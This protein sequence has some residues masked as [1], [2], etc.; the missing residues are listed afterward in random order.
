MPPKRREEREGDRVAALELALERAR[1]VG[2]ALR[3]VGMAVGSTEELEELLTLIVNTTTEV[4]EAERAT[5]YLLDESGRLVSRV[6]KGGELEEIVLDVGQG[7]AGDVAATGEPTRVS[8]AYEDPRFDREWDVKS[9]FRTRS[10]LGVPVKNHAGETIGVL[11]VLNKRAR[12]GRASVFTPFDQELLVALATQAAVS[13]DKA[14]LFARLKSQNEELQSTTRRLERTLRDLELLYDIESHMSRADTVS[15]LAR[16]TI[17]LTAQACSA[18]AGALLYQPADGGDLTLY[19]VNTQEPTEVREVVVQPGEGIAARALDQGTVLNI[20]SARQ[21]RDPRR[22]RELLG[23]S[24]RTA[25]AAPLLGDFHGVGGALALYNHEKGAT[26]SDEDASLLRL[27]SVNVHTQLMLLDSRRQRERAERIGSVGNLLSGVMHDL[28]TPLSVI[29]GYVQ[30]MA[31]TEDAATRAKQLET[32]TEQFEIIAAMQRDLLAYARGDTTLLIRK[33]YLGRFGEALARQFGPELERHK[34]RLEL[35]LRNSGV[36]Y[37]DEG[38]M[39]RALGNLVRNA[40]EALE[41]SRR[42]GRLHV[43]TDRDGED[44]VIQVIDNGPGVPRGIR[45][46]LFEPFVTSG[47]KTG[48]GLGLSNVRKIVEEHGGTIDVESSSSGTVFTIT[49]PNAM[50]PHALEI[51][52]MRPAASA[53]G[54]LPLTQSLPPISTRNLPPPSRPPTSKPVRQVPPLPA[55]PED[56]ALSESVIPTAS[57]TRVRQRKSKKGTRPGAGRGSLLES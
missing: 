33:V 50:K 40:I 4:L 30:L 43:V 19:V 47:K 45:K 39:L 10:I 28:K 11:Q 18:S 14:A 21:V 7:V 51:E 3:R 48:T 34:I 41:K 31:T 49:I 46:K 5:L 20:G 27:V 22:V 56:A 52:S 36:A 1:A 8:D 32:V 57:E 15:E 44:L 55:L 35:D 16:C 13:V 24:V 6:K 25:I 54:P 9:G 38:N 37:F 2:D 26:F 42:K 29:S 12:H 17:L 23:I 53:R